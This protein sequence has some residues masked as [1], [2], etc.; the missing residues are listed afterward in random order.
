MSQRYIGIKNGIVV[1]VD[2]ISITLF[3]GVYYSAYSR[4]PVAFSSRKQLLDSMQELFDELQ[5]PFMNRSPRSF[6]KEETVYRAPAHKEILMKDEELLNKKGDLGTF[7][8]RVQH[9]QNASWQG[10][11]TWL[12]KDQTLNFRSIWE[13]TKLMDSALEDNYPEEEE[14][15]PAWKEEEK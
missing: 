7:I 11:I 1:C 2:R 15:T 4:E 14:K 9:R 12:E 6:R 10:R 8:I 13:M 3:Q 5:F